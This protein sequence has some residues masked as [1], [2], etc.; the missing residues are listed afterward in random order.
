MI[1]TE[2]KNIF[3]ASENR[4]TGLYPSGNSYSLT[5]THHIKFIKRVE[6]LHASVPNTIFNITNG[7]DVIDVSGNTYSLPSGFYSATGIAAELTNTLQN[8]TDISVIFMSNEAKFVFY[9]ASTI[10]SGGTAFNITAGTNEFAKVMGL[11]PPGTTLI[12]TEPA[13][14]SGASVPL[15]SGHLLYDGKE[16]IKTPGVAQMHPHEG[17]FLDIEEL[18]TNNNEDAVPLTGNTYSGQN[19]SRSFA[20]IPLDVN[21]GEIKRFNKNTDYDFAI[22]Y[23]YPIQSLSKL[24]VR[25]LDNKGKQVNFNGYEDNSFLLRFHTLKKIDR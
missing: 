23:P 5:L 22:D 21:S 11:P 12:A 14:P 1:T 17:V 10:S 7:T 15:G 24:T 19:I 6:L 13:I 8:N 3:V 20:L 4:D 18:R 16:F 25:W 9:K 2:Y